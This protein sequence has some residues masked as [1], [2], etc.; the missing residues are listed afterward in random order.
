MAAE[1]ASRTWQLPLKQTAE[2]VMKR[3]KNSD[4]KMVG[5]LHLVR[6]SK[7]REH[8]AEAPPHQRER[9]RGKVES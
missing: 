3:E 7:K 1:H 2:E 4:T 6:E 5:A 8:M 9:E